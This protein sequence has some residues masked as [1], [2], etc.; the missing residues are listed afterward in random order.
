MKYGLSMKLVVH[1]VEGDLG[2]AVEPVVEQLVGLDESNAQLLDF[3]VGSDATNRTVDIEVT[4]EAPTPEEAVAV[5]ASCVRSAIHA[6]GAATPGWGG[7]DSTN[8]VVIYEIGEGG[9]EIRPLAPA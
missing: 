9:M 7:R 6:T 1:G 4:V 3:G 8:D 5:G 2:D